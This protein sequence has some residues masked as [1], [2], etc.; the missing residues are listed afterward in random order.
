[1]T[2]K[3]TSELSSRFM[4]LVVC[5]VFLIGVVTMLPAS[6]VSTFVNFDR[7][8]V[9]YMAANGT[10]WNGSFENVNIGSAPL[11]DI[12]FRLSALSLLTLF[13]KFDLSAKEGAVIGDAIVSVNPAQRITIADLNAD[14]DLG[15]LAPYGILGAPTQGIARVS[16]D[17]I[18]L[19]PKKGCINADGTLWTNVLNAPAFRHDMP[20]LPLNGDVTCE[21]EQLLV[22]LEGENDRAGAEII[23]R[24][25]KDLAYELAARAYS[26]EDDINSALRFLGFEDADGELV[27]GSAGIFRSAGS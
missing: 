15:A 26:P 2:K 23:L 3:V 14:L 24:I 16:A 4:G 22:V 27:Y 7:Q 6:L 10:I 17:K 19:S 1:M 12:S 25:N 20:A 8:R 21:G 11:G 5:A 13:P 9:S 18:A